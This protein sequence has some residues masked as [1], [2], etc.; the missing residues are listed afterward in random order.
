MGLSVSIGAKEPLP[1]SRSAAFG[2]AITV[3]D[4]VAAGWAC[5]TRA[6]LTGAGGSASPVFWRRS[7]M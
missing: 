5:N 4:N 2:S 3:D 7:S 6:R 1:S